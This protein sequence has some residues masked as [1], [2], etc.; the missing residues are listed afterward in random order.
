[1]NMDVAL[2][3]TVRLDYVHGFPEVLLDVPSRDL[4]RHLRG[5]TLF[6][7]PGKHALPLF[8]SVLLHGNESTGWAAVQSVV[9]HYQ[10]KLPRKLLLFVGNVEAAKHNVRTLPHQ[11]DYN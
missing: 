4:W 6:Y 11:Y 8:V 9:R 7:V 3:E 10:A 5:P 2:P 1:M